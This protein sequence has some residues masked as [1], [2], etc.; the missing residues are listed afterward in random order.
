MLPLMDG[1]ETDTRSAVFSEAVAK[2]IRAAWRGDQK[3]IWVP[4]HTPKDWTMP[5]RT[6]CFALDADPGERKN[7][8]QGSRDDVAYVKSL[9]ERLTAAPLASLEPFRGHRDDERLRSLGYL[10]E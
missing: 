3:T 7:I 2:K 10:E 9:W 5:Q 1:Q 6:L 4:E 8:A